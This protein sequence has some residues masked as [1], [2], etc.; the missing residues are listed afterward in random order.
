MKGLTEQG[1]SEPSPTPR[2]SHAQN[3]DPG[4]AEVLLVDDLGRGRRPVLGSDDVAEAP[5]QRPV[6]R[7]P[8]LEGSR[9]VA[10]M[11]LERLLERLVD[12]P[13]RAGLERDAEAVGPHRR[14]RLLGEVDDHAV[15]AADVAVAAALEQFLAAF[16]P[17]RRTGSDRRQALLDRPALAPVEEQRP[18]APLLA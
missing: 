12:Q 8:L 1:L 11:I 18:G 10:E 3:R 17:G 16:V 4:G 15:E 9:L 14:E 6:L 7:D 5:V 13:L 2:G